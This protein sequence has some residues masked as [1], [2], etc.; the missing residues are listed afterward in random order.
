MPYERWAVL[1][2]LLGVLTTSCRLRT[3][4]A[5]VAIF[6]ILLLFLDVHA[7]LIL[8]TKVCPFRPGHLLSAK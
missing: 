7:D 5:L 4:S 3:V 6:G 1:C 8:R 2:A